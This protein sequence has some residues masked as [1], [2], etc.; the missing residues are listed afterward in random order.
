MIDKLIQPNTIKYNCIIIICFIISIF[1][2]NTNIVDNFIKYDISYRLISFVKFKFITND[3]SRKVFDGYS[4]YFNGK[5]DEKNIKLIESSLEKV[6]EQ[7]NNI[8]GTS[9][10]SPINIVL[11][12][13]TDEFANNFK[14]EAY[15]DAVSI[16][17]YKTIY[18]CND[19]ISEHAVIHEYNHYMFDYFCKEN[20]IKVYNIPNWFQEGVAEYNT[21]LS[22]KEPFNKKSL[23]KIKRFRSLDTPA[24][25]A[26]AC[27]DGYDVYTQAYLAIKT[28]VSNNKSNIIQNILIQS[29]TMNF[30]DALQKNTKENIEDIEKLIIIVK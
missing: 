7:K 12:L 28:I 4:L 17:G 9:S 15:K 22:T 2:L 20:G 8:L 5:S 23:N 14:T 26:K 30:Y 24:D 27:A 10:I 11:F 18:L 1:I 16:Y 29:K 13:T 19:T 21:Y 3:M 6:R 25:V